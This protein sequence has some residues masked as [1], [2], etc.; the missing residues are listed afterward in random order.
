[1][2]LFHTCGPK[3]LFP[4]P[5]SPGKREGV[6]ILLCMLR[7]T[8]GPLNSFCPG[9]AHGGT[10]RVVTSF[11]LFPHG[12]LIIHAQVQL[13]ALSLETIAKDN[14]TPRRPMAGS[15]LWGGGG[16]KMKRREGKGDNNKEGL[17]GSENE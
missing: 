5:S 4:G 16:F 2:D 10:L 3:I 12:Q 11:A 1:M 17:G 7:M 15:H 9:Q 6:D 14:T 8:V 13:L